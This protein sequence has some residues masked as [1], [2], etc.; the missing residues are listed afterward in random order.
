MADLLDLMTNR[1]L[2][3]RKTSTNNGGEYC[4]ACPRCGDG[5][6]GLKSDRFHIWPA[7]ETS[8]LGVGRFWCR[9]CGISGDSIAFLQKIDGLSFPDACNELGIILPRQNNSRRTR[10]YQAPPVAPKAQYGWQPT[11][12]PEPCAL[13]QEKAGNLLVDCQARLL[14]AEAALAW[15]AGRGITAAMAEAYGLGYNLSSRGKDRYRPR[16]SWGLPEKKQNGKPKKLWIPRGWVIPSRNAAG[17]LVQLRIRR[18]DE[19]IAAFGSN[20]KYLPLDG[21]SA[22]TMVL[23]RQAEVFV[24]VECGF[25]AILLDWLMEGKIGVTTSWNNAARPDTSTNALFQ[26]ASLI[27]GALDY[28]KGGDSEQGW[29]KK[30]YR[31]YKRLPAL[32]GGAADPGEAFSAGVDLRAWII[33]GLPRGLQIKLG[34]TG[35]KLAPA[36]KAAPSAAQTPAPYSAPAAECFEIELTNGTLIYVTNDQ[37]KWQ[38]LID[39]GKPVFS[40]NELDRLKEA[41]ATMNDADRLAAAMQVI[42][43]KQELGGYVRD[44]RALA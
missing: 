19:D 37:A 3:P 31:Q 25:D 35:K 23:H 34:F 42:T 5:E 17:Q 26:K 43:V 38:E 20:I 14:E 39:A 44:G 10:R 4:S 32:A 7:K 28:D 11:T 16:A 18:L 40:Q 24:P 30:Q 8:G 36:A 15:L 33:D 2:S 22:A 27:L 6:K 1:G 29:W 41:T 21:S 9:S 12:Y 13:W